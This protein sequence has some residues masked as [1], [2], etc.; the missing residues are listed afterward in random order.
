MAVAELALRTAVLLIF[1]QAPATPPQPQSPTGLILGRVVDGSSGRPVPS[2]IVTIAGGG[3]GPAPAA[4]GGAQ[5][6]AITNSNGQFVFRR[7]PKGSFVLTATKPGYVEGAY[8]RSLPSGS[9]LPLE[10][11]DR[12]R[13]TDV[14]IPIWRFASIAGTVTDEAGEPLVGVEVRAFERQYSGGR[15]RLSTGT[16]QSTD[17][18]GMY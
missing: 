9:T 7:L 8:G 14:V 11:A 18:R 10:L 1:F 16:S 2:A 4:G 12:Q 5:P 3:I 15:R 6:R 17:D 13:T